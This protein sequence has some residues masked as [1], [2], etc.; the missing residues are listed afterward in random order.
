[1]YV[2]CYYGKW[3][4]VSIYTFFR[5]KREIHIYSIKLWLCKT[6]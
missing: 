2:L 6:Y 1:M 3:I 4:S 5:A